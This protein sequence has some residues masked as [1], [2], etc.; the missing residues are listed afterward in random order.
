MT[1][2]TRAPVIMPS[3]ATPKRISNQLTIRPPGEVTN[4]ESPWPEDG[5]D[6]PVERVEER[7]ERPSGFSSS[8][9]RIAA[10]D[11]EH[12]DALGRASRKKRR[13]SWPATRRRC[14]ATRRMIGL[15]R[16]GWASGRLASR[17]IVPQPGPGARRPSA[18]PGAGRLAAGGRAPGRHVGDSASS[19]ATRSAGARW[20]LTPMRAA[21]DGDRSSARSRRRR[22]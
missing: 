22:R 12:D 17:P 20:R 5:G 3:M 10:I 21:A 19:A 14:H 7:F 4:A 9:M 15:A 2:A 18:R 13:S 16:T 8:V 11:D 1:I 6:P